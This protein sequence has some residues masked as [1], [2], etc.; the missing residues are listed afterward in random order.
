MFGSAWTQGFVQGQEYRDGL[1]NPFHTWIQVGKAL[2]NHG[3]GRRR[4]HPATS[5]TFQPQEGEGMLPQGYSTSPGQWVG[6]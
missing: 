2:N 3:E 5:A 4:L 1:T 6:D